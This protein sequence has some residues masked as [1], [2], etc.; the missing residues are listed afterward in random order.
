MARRLTTLRA[1]SNSLS[2][3]SISTLADRASSTTASTAGPSYSN[4]YL[5]ELKAANLSKSLQTDQP[6]EDPLYGQDSGE[7]NSSS[8]ARY[9]AD[10]DDFTVTAPS[11]KL[12]PTEDAIITAKVQRETAR[13]LGIDNP[14]APSSSKSD[15]YISLQ[16]G[17]PT[18]KRE[19]RL[20]R[21]EDELGEGEDDF[22]AF[23]GAKERIALGRKGRKDM[24]R[25]R[26]EE[27]RALI[28][29]GQDDD[30]VMLLGGK[31]AQTNDDDDEEER[32]W[33][34]AQI[35]RGEQRRGAATGEEDGEPYRPA[36]SKLA[37]PCTFLPFRADSHST[38][39]ARST[40][41]ASLTNA[42]RYIKAL[43][44]RPCRT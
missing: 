3:A 13:R 43:E 18:S 7:Y 12:L 9:G 44:E 22:S 1:L 28:E 42:H 17:M 24:E 33:E 34:L 14:S 30:D 4:D 2:Q 26:K 16:V 38:L 29:G 21:E 27:M 11:E 41:T 10:G 8:I 25:K 40:R 39:L 5:N 32:E 31:K 20:V 19:S 6:V 15:D 23:T 35:R 37:S 36:S